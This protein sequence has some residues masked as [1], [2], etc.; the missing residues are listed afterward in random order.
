M[1][2]RECSHETAPI[3]PALRYPCVNNEVW[4][5][6]GKH[7]VLQA[8]CTRLSNGATC[9]RENRKETVQKLYVGEQGQLPS[10]K[11]KEAKTG[12]S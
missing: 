8:G 10:P 3:L 6:A 12:R 7:G 4:A 5:M 9:R 11:S 1:Q 2:K